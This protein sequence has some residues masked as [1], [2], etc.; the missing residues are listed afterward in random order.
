MSGEGRLT[1]FPFREEGTCS[2]IAEAACA[3]TREK[4]S[5][6]P[7]SGAGESA[8]STSLSLPT[9]PRTITAGEEPGEEEGGKRV[10][11][12]PHP[13]SPGSQAG[14]W[15]RGAAPGAVVSQNRDCFRKGN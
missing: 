9:P 11:F 7:T 13:G 15:I 8:G 2:S 1:W 12:L 6:F 3:G 10:V 4:R 14:A 5:F